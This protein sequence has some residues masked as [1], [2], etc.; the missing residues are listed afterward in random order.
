MIVAGTPLKPIC[1]TVPVAGAGM[2]G[3]IYLLVLCCAFLSKETVLIMTGLIMLFLLSFA[4]S[5]KIYSKIL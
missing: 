3:A 1:I 5:R 4:I 2:I